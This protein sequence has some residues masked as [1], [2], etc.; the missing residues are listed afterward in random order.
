MIFKTPIRTERLEMIPATA[1]IL[2]SD[3]HG[4][5][6]LARIVNAVV[7]ASWPPEHLS[8]DVIREF[9]RMDADKTTPCFTSW[10]WIRNDTE[11]GIRILIGSGGIVS[12]QDPEGTVVIG[13]GVLDEYQ[14]LGYATEAVRNLIP[15]IFR[16]PEIS[17]ILATTYPELHASVRVLEKNGFV[18]SQRCPGGGEGI[19]EGTLCYERQRD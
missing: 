8:K 6:S 18:L 10:Y 4:H 5:A 15:V 7:P 12:L 16:N 14:G 19:E 9:L 2:R 11:R 17:C 13:Y 1:E 3:L